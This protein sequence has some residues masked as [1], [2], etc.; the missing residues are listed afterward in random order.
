VPQKQKLII[1]LGHPVEELKT[2]GDALKT[3]SP[4]GLSRAEIQQQ[5]R[6]I[7]D[8]KEYQRLFHEYVRYLKSRVAFLEQ[9]LRQAGRK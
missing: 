2:L 5:W 9:Q 3:L 7:K 8:A 1:E 4:P 6:V